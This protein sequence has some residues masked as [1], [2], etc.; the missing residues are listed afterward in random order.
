MSA[1]RP[2]TVCRPAAALFLFFLTAS[3]QAASL[4]KV[5]VQTGNLSGPNVWGLDFLLQ[6]GGEANPLQAQIKNLQMTGARLLGSGVTIVGSRFVS[7]SLANVLTLATTEGGDYSELVQGLAI[8]NPGSKM[9]FD[10]I[11][12]ANRPQAASCDP[13]F[14]SFRL[15]DANGNPLLTDSPEDNVSVIYAPFETAAPSAQSFTTE[16][17]LV[18]TQLV[19]AA[20]APE[21]ASFS[22]FL[23]GLLGSAV[24]A[25]RRSSRKKTL[26]Y[27]KVKA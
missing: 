6:N 18:T 21:P 19:L 10:L 9:T 22:Y 5:T 8:S 14:F 26:F 3:A 17:P 1:F 27:V 13:D 24:V 20:A 2:T 23:P 7:G 15:L 4:Y 16:A 11:L 25:V 12:S